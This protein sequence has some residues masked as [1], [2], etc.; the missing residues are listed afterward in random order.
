MRSAFEQTYHAQTDIES[1]HVSRA[2]SRRL[3]E[4]SAYVLLFFIVTFPTMAFS[5]N[6][7]RFLVAVLVAL[8][9]IRSLTTRLQL[10]RTVARWT[11]ILSAVSVLF[12]I[13]GLFLLAPG[14]L[15]QMQV[16]AAWPLVYLVLISGADCLI[17]H[18]L[19]RTLIFSAIFIPRF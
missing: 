19:E 1:L 10:D 7:K 15:M 2:A 5:L 12:G 11:L 6:P 4:W 14:A 3:G 17:L 8:I 16:Y 18:G 9:G 13:R